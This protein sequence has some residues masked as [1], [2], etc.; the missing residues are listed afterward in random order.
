MATSSAASYHGF[1]TMKF[2]HY[3]ARNRLITSNVK[4]LIF[5]KSNALQKMGDQSDVE[6]G[7]IDDDGDI[8]DVNTSHNHS[9][10]HSE[11]VVIDE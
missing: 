8:P 11:I 4:K 5:I 2:L 7:A 9:L 3:S 1:S 6:W 10:G